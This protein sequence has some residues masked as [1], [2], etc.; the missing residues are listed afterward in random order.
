MKKN[1]HAYTHVPIAYYFKCL[2]MLKLIVVFI[3]AFAANLMAN[4]S[5]AQDYVTLKYREAK[6]KNI[7]TDI[8]KQTDVAFIYNEDA[9]KN[10]RIDNI[11]VERKKW[12]EFLLPILAKNSLQIEFISNDR[13]VIK[14]SKAVQTTV[15]TGI[16]RDKNNNPLSNV[17][18]K[19]VNSIKS[20]LTDAEGKFALE[21]T[22]SNIVLHFSSVGFLAKELPA[23]QGLMQIVLEEDLAQLDE[24]VV[25]GYGTQKRINLTGSVSTISGSELENRPVVNATQSLQGAMPGLNVSVNGATKPGQ[26]FKLNVRG[27]GN[28]SGSDQPYVLV[29]GLEMSLADVNPSDIENISVL[30][31]ASAG[32]IY[33][34]RAAYGVIL[35]TTKSG[36]AGRKQINFTSNTGFTTPV[37]LP[38]MVNSVEF[39]NYFN[40]ATFNA[41]GTRQYS[42]EKIALLQQYINDPTSVS[43]FPEV[44]N[45]TY[46]SWEN[47]ANGVAN[48]NWFD[49]HYKPYAMRQNYNVNLSGGNEGTQFFVSGGLYDEGGSLRYADINYNR[50]NFNVSVNSQLTDFIKV[51]SN[52][53]YTQNANKTPLAGYEDMFFHNLA[54]MRPNVSPYD[55]YGNWNEQSMIPYLQSGSEGKTN[56]GTLVLLGGLEISPL[57]NW[58]VFADLNFRRS[59]YDGSTLKLPGTIYGI[60]GT[61]ISVNRSEYNIPL[62]G[63]F[64]RTM[65]EQNYI[66]PNIYTNYKMQFDKHQIDLTAGFQ[67]E[68]MQYKE[69]TSSATELISFDRPGTD[70]ATGTKSS[71]EARN[72]WATR[73]FFARVNYNFANKYLLEVNGRYDGS[74]RFAASQRWGFFPSV[75]AGYNISEEDFFKDNVSWIDQL[76]IRG[77]YGNLGNQA[78]ANMY[79]Y[80][81][82]MN[83]IISGPGTGGRYYF[84]N[85]RESYIQAP[86][87][88]NPLITWEKVQSMNIG[89]DFTMLNQRLSGT[90][91]WYQRNTRDMLGP[92][93]DVADMFGA[94]APQ[95]NNADLQ[96]RGWEIS[97]KWRDRINDDWSYDVGMMLTDYKSIVTKYQNPTN[98]NPGGAWYEGKEVGEIWGYTSHG[99][100]K[101]V[102]EANAYNQLNRS[103][104]SAR[105]WVVGD[106][107]YEDING[108]GKIDIG[109]NRLGDMGD[110]STI[111]NSS[112]RYNFSISGGLTWKDWSMNM[113]WQGVGKQNYLP[114]AL[115]AYFWGSGSLAQVTV[116]QKHL[117]YYTPENPDAYFPNPYASPVGAISS[118]T[119][120]TQSPSSRYVQ[121]ASF[122]RLKNLTL[123]YSVPNEVSKRIGINRLSVFGSGENLL[124]FTKLVKMFDPETLAGGSGTG[125]M[126]PLSKV[127][128]FGV[129]LT[130]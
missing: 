39:A 121:N 4:E 97:L 2:I 99:L 56:N 77:S 18:V 103:Y 80:L 63:S 130:F 126:Y 29:D 9:V 24:V 35:V 89:A 46:G 36:K 111:G 75:S 90:L 11:A 118:Y 28:L 19:Q 78:G 106:V 59:N 122:I 88:F 14:A 57:K 125:K 33:G 60:D 65:S 86:A 129:N 113:L 110:Y 117:D 128:S 52:V 16:V 12:K 5:L 66:T 6:L 30:K 74:S 62:T 22:G 45:N 13:A 105:D 55:F 49:L 120:K 8:E 15:V 51:K 94:T 98:F 64:S 41:L 83:I 54:R 37:R 3:T 102:E 73:G 32:A 81:E 104:L 85:D 42:E 82:S 112:P 69:L 20:T 100:L 84:G 76:K 44:S 58:K 47:S 119:N 107:K 21:T 101:T 95:T 71:N 108:D 96:T 53:K 72:H 127:Y 17:S 70:L 91:E 43:I 31:D 61:P 93:R 48:T 67:Q 25:V 38:D 115:D 116:F 92:S 109:A 1:S 79:A 50:Y 34:S 7:L 26:S 123:Q 40:A 68:Y 124:T 114:A 10:V 23:E 27:T 87:A